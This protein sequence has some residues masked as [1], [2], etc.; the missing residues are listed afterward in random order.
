MDFMVALVKQAKN[1][2]RVRVT[3]KNYHINKRLYQFEAKLL[4]DKNLKDMIT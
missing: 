4:L 3:D 2:V 1:F